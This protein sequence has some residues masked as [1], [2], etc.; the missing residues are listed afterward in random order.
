MA[1]R[2]RSLVRALIYCM[3][4]D[5][6]TRQLS[7]NLVSSADVSELSWT[8]IRRRRNRFDHTMATMRAYVLVFSTPLTHRGAAAVRL[9]GDRGAPEV[10]VDATRQFVTVFSQRNLCSR[11]FA[12][13]VGGLA[14]HCVDLDDGDKLSLQSFQSVVK[15]GLAD[16]EAL[17]GTMTR[18]VPPP[19][20]TFLPFL[21][22]PPLIYLN[23][24]ND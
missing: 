4:C 8:V 11:D 16:I 9:L 19:P 5:T 12:M 24:I 1:E 17:L 14:D 3:K 23:M 15:L 7:C 6:M 10:S 13:L 20:P 18:R 2:I 21:P 22:L